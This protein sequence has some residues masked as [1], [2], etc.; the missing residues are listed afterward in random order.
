MSNL[1][2][3]SSVDGNDKG[4]AMFDLFTRDQSKKIQMVR[5]IQEEI[6]PLKFAPI[7]ERAVNLDAL[8]T[9]LYS[10]MGYLALAAQEVPKDRSELADQLLSLRRAISDFRVKMLSGDP[11]I[12]DRLAELS[13]GIVWRY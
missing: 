7:D 10:T 2:A 5:S 9:T 8:A 6:S 11:K 12:P 3:V 4:D 13:T 1:P